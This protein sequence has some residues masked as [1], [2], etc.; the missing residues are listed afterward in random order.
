MDRE[1]PGFL[2]LSTNFF[3]KPIAAHRIVTEGMLFAILFQP[4][5][6]HSLQPELSASALRMFLRTIPVRGEGN[7]RN[8]TELID[9]VDCAGLN[10]AEHSM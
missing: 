3:R 9:Y 4:S 10:L 5:T 8:C 1:P 6:P 2:G 7:R